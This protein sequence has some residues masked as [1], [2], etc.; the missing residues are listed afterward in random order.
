M[1][2]PSHATGRH[3]VTNPPDRIWAFYASEI[4]DDNQGCTIVAGE[5]CMHGAAPY[6]RAD[7]A[8]AEIA[9]LRAVLETIKSASNHYARGDCDLSYAHQST[10]NLAAAALASKP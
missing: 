3:T 5:S 9:R 6:V 4:G 10:H 7:I 8:A 1:A 2:C